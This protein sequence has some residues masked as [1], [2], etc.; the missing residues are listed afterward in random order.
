MKIAYVSPSP[1][2][3]NARFLRLPFGRRLF[4]LFLRKI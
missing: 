2:V 1:L 3:F 4:S